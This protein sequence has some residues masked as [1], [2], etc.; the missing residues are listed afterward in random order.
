MTLSCKE[1]NCIQEGRI[2]KMEERLENFMVHQTSEL[3]EIK[4]DLKSLSNGGLSSAIQEQ[5]QELVE[6][7][8]SLLK[9]EKKAQADNADKERQAE[10]QMASEEGQRELEKWKLI[11]KILGGGFGITALKVLYD[12][13]KEL[14][15][16]GGG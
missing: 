8:V 10:F 2:S 13:F 16:K 11:A 6:Q 3:H 1:G 14:L 5:N 12:L 15:S 4:K 7:L 9:E